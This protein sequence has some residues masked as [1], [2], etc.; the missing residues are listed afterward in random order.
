M[1]WECVSYFA[2]TIDQIAN[3]NNTA[4]LYDDFF[5]VISLNASRE[6]ASKSV[7]TMLMPCSAKLDAKS[8]IL[9][10]FF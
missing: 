3:I 1:L 5:L 7:F 9:S 6:S 8:S 10:T 4:V 2:F